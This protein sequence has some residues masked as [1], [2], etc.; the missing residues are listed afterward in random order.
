MIP[1]VHLAAAMDVFRGAVMVLFFLS[2]F[3]VIVVVLLQEGKGGGIAGAFGGAGAET[4]GVK[5]GT[6]N[7][8]TSWL[9]AFFLGLALLH[10]GLTNAD[11]DVPDKPGTERFTG[12]DEEDGAEAGAGD[13]AG[14]D[15]GDD[16]GGEGGEDDGGGDGDEGGEDE[17]GGD[18]DGEPE[19]GGGD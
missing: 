1:D 6:V 11:D 2:S 16:A 12:G 10:A 15:A 9:A 14:D 5:A 4:F 19:D 8:F 3:M 13:E 17:D 7:M 18:G